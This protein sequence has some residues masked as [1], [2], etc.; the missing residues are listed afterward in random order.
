M[1]FVSVAALAENHVIGK[2]G[3]VPWR[4]PEDRR[5][6]RSRIAED[7][8]ILGRVTYESMIEDL[9]ESFQIVMSRSDREYDLPTAFHAGDVTE[10]AEITDFHDADRAYVHR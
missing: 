10:A 7:P 9:P 4:I 8:V 1:E 6:Y 2:D 3:E 5:Q